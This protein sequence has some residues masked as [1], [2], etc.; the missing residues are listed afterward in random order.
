M[1]SAP[2]RSLDFRNFGLRVEADG[3]LLQ[4]GNGL[5]LRGENGNGAPHRLLDGSRG[6]EKWDLWTGG[7]TQGRVMGELAKYLK[8]S[9][10]D[11]KR[12]RV[13][14]QPKSQD[15]CHRPYGHTEKLKGSHP[16]SGFSNCESAA[17][18]ARSALG[19]RPKTRR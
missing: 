10:P 11:S 17:A 9:S 8:T 4:Y 12:D 14:P 3:Q 1:H 2:D 7:G 5:W 6:D 13:T 15:E 16:Q 19:V 18:P